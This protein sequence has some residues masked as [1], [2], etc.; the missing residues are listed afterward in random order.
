MTGGENV[1]EMLVG[2]DKDETTLQLPRS[3]KKTQVENEQLNYF[4]QKIA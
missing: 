3:A 2:W 1:K 4:Q